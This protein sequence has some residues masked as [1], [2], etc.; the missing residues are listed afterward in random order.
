MHVFGHIASLYSVQA[1]RVYESSA[2]SV[3]IRN[4]N[5]NRNILNSYRKKILS[6]NCYIEFK[7]NGMPG[8]VCVIEEYVS[9]PLKN[10]NNCLDTAI[11]LVLSE[12]ALLMQEATEIFCNASVDISS[13]PY[14]SSMVN[15]SNVVM[16]NKLLKISRWLLSAEEY[17]QG[18]TTHLPTIVISDVSLAPPFLEYADFPDNAKRLLIKTDRLSGRVKHL[19]TLFHEYFTDSSWNGLHRQLNAQCTMLE[20]YLYVP[21]RTSEP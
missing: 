20:Q 8:R 12:T 10:S 7:Q 21:L 14:T 3:Y 15:A 9:N 6:F 18:M 19:N 17:L 2:R 11:K 5:K 4:L 13:S 1:V 16:C